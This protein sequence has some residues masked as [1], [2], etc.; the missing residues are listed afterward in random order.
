[1]LG[2]MADSSGLEEGMGLFLS[3]PIPSMSAVLPILRSDVC[4]QRKDSVFSKGLK[5]MVPLFFPCVF[6]V[7]VDD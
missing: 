3:T 5:G 7:L 2:N 4:G 1:M 6:T